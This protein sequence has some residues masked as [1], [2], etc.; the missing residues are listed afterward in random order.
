MPKVDIV[1]Y[2]NE[3]RCSNQDW[4]D[5]RVYHGRLYMFHKRYCLGNSNPYATPS[6]LEASSEYKDGVHVDV[7]MLDH[8]LL[9]FSTQPFNNKWDS[10]KIGEFVC[11]RSELDQIE[12]VQPLECYLSKILDEY[13]AVVNGDRFDLYIEIDGEPAGYLEDVIVDSSFEDYTKQHIKEI[14]AHVE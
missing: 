10:G 12:A 7:Y 2:Y 14:M 6:E 4:L 13:S 8:S 3:P 11:T 1:V 9:H 5:D